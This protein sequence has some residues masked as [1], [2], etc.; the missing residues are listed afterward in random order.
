M[1]NNIVNNYTINIQDYFLFLKKLFKKNKINKAV[2]FHGNLPYKKKYLKI[3]KKISFLTFMC[4]KK[5][6]VPDYNFKILTK[7]NH[8]K[9]L[10]YKYF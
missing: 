9:K 4:E 10:F 3:N 7:D 6:N 2:F 5:S 1:K 8:V